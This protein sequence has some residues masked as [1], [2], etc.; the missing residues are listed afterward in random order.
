MFMQITEIHCLKAVG[1][2]YIQLTQK[3]ASIN[4]GKGSNDKV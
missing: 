1:A 4:L 2:Y 3:G